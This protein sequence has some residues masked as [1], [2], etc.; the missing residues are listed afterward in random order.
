MTTFPEP[1]D[2][3]A[4]AATSA[5]THYPNLARAGCPPAGTI[6]QLIREKVPPSPE[7]RDHLLT[8]SPCYREYREALGAARAAADTRRS[9]RLPRVLGMAVAASIVAVVGALL[10][11]STSPTSAPAVGP[12]TSKPPIVSGRETPNAFPSIRID[13]TRST[14]LR[15]IPNGA[16]SADAMITVP[17]A[18]ID[19]VLDLPPRS[20]SGTYTVRIVDAFGGDLRRVA[21][22]TTTATITAAI[23]F[24]GL[25]PG[26]V[27]LCVARADEVPDCRPLKISRPVPPSGSPG[28]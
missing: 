22:S 25:E 13:M 3:I 17:P 5:A 11:R 8:C 24:A 21:V 23:D 7:L 10:F 14:N 4:A 19:V 26:I 15:H 16:S 18:R 27:R 6:V 2:L 1:E 20:P 12:P 9:S 28:S